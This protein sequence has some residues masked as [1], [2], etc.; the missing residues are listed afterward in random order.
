MGDLVLIAI[1]SSVFDLSLQGIGVTQPMR[2]TV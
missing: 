2:W 1:T